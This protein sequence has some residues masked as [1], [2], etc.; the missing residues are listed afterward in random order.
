[1]SEAMTEMAERL[2]AS[3]RQ[4]IVDVHLECGLRIVHDTP[5]TVS[6]GGLPAETFGGNTWRISD[7]EVAEWEQRTGRTFVARG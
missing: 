5:I 3:C 6:G 7:Q 1:M 2:G 4:T